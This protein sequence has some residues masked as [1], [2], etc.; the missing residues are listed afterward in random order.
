MQRPGTPKIVGAVVLVALIVAMA[1]NTKFVTPKELASIGPTTFSPEKTAAELFKKAGTEFGERAAPLPEVVT[2]IQAD[3]KAAAAK[4]KAVQPNAGTLVF[5]VTATG[6]V[7]Q[8]TA[9]SLQ[10]KVDG[11]PPQT[12]VL[13]P[14]TTA[15]NG[16]VLRDALG[17]KFADAPGQSDFQ[18][19]GDELK[20]LM[21]AAVTDGIGDPA[22]LKG[23]Q[24]TVLGVI[25]VVGEG[26]PPKEK[27]V[28]IQP[29]SVKEGS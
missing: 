25:S 11:V 23:K 8:A 22:A 15:I 12:L 28:N 3:P 2:A 26:A 16:T 14:V 17:F 4:Y 29:V 6:T 7:T 10:L 24:I 5:A 9:A 27:P 1:L 20:K 13:V 19:V 18:F 21:Q